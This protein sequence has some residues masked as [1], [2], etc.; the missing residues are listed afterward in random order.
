MRFLRRQCRVLLAVSLGFGTA[1][2]QADTAPVTVENAWARA[3]VAGQQAS[4]AFMRLTAAEPLR[5]VGAETPVAAVGE[6]HEMRMD[7]E[8]MRMRA[9]EALELPA[10]TAVELK[11]GSYHVMLLQLKQ[12]LDAGTHIPLTLVF[13]DAQ[14]QTSRLN[15]QVPVRALQA[16]GHKAS[17]GA[18]GGH[19]KD[20]HG[21][22]RH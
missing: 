10:G 19:G 9:I 16:G 20:G 8:V 18:H 17:G 14:G 6:I 12:A 4:G 7:G 11:P 2:A 5:L 22:H 1:Y 15:L 21:H 13:H 3:T